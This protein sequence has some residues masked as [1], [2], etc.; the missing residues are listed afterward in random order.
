MA[1]FHGVDEETVVVGKVDVV[2]VVGE[3]MVGAPSQLVDLIA[4]EVVVGINLVVAVGEIILP[5][6]VARIHEEDVALP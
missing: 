3:E 6:G 5:V 1:A 2:V 4:V